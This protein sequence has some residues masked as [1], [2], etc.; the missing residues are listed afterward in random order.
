MY[1]AIYIPPAKIDLVF[2][3]DDCCHSISLLGDI[4][5]RKNKR[6]DQVNVGSPMSLFASIVTIKPCLIQRGI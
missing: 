4:Q 1:N 5:Q 2:R 3:A 6:L